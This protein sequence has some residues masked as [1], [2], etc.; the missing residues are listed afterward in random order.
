MIDI[1]NNHIFWLDME[2]TGL[3]PDRDLP[4]EIGV[5]V[6]GFA[7]EEVASYS[8]FVQQDIDSVSRLMDDN[9]WWDKRP[10]Y[11]ANMLGLIESEGKPAE[12]IETDLEV[13]ASTWCI[14]PVILAGNSV[15]NDR[16]WLKIHFPALESRTHYRMIDVTSFKLMAQAVLGQEYPKSEDHRALPDV[17]ESIAELRECLTVYGPLIAKRLLEPS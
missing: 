4:L 17:R 3:D 14:D 7:L 5:A 6:T 13:L 10:E 2:M 1:D 12:Q 9:P 15:Y 8:A 11:R 16:G